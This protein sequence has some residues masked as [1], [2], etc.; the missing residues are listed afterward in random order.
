MSNSNENSNMEV[1]FIEDAPYV[2]T[3]QHHS[4][5]WNRLEVSD[6]FLTVSEIRGAEIRYINVCLSIERPLELH[7]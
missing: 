5:F 4:T 3:R 1:V 6:G 7:Q 2:G